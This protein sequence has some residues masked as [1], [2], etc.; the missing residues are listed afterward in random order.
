MEAA[1]SIGVVAVV[2]GLAL[3]NNTVTTTSEQ[4]AVVA[5]VILHLVAVV[6]VLDALLHHAVT[7]AG[8]DATGEAGVLIG[9]VAVV[10]GLA[11]LHP[12]GE[13]AP[14]HAVAATSKAAGA[15]TAVRVDS[16]TV[17]AGFVT[18]RVGLKLVAGD[19]VTADAVPTIG[20]AVIPC[21]LVAVVAVLSELHGAVAALRRAVPD[22]HLLGAG[23]KGGDDEDCAFVHRGSCYWQA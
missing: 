13:V 10:A 12:I 23:E 15:R 9:E 14:Q 18:R 17:V 6:T 20:G 4:A 7:A 11:T 19:T 22:D 16:V 3:L 21:Y 1:V 8:G 5:A 2:A